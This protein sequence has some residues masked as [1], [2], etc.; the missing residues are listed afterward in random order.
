MSGC[1]VVVE[2]DALLDEFGEVCWEKELM[3]IE[4]IGKYS[5]THDQRQ[6]RQSLCFP[7]RWKQ[8]G[9]KLCLEQAFCY[10]SES[11]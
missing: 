8:I 10:S 4:C 1:K 3:P 5:R 2:Q 9:R 11:G 6:R 7:A